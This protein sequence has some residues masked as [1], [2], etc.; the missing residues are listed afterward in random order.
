MQ[1]RPQLLSTLIQKFLPTLRQ[2]QLAHLLLAQSWVVFCYK[3]DAWMPWWLHLI[4]FSPL[5]QQPHGHLGSARPKQVDIQMLPFATN[6]TMGMEQR[7][8]TLIPKRSQSDKRSTVLLLWVEVSTVL[9]LS[10]TTRIQPMLDLVHHLLV[11]YMLP[12]HMQHLQ[13]S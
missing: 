12:N 10:T 9:L 7:T 11:S 1:H 2:Q 6:A 13:N 8:R 4:L 3:Q 5:K